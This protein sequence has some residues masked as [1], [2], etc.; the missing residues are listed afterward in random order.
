MGRMD[1]CEN[2]IWMRQIV[3]MFIFRWWPSDII[4]G[5]AKDHRADVLVPNPPGT[6]L[7][8]RQELE[9]IPTLRWH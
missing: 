9:S 8:L 4:V 7:S 1:E 2:G 6:G 3:R 5:F